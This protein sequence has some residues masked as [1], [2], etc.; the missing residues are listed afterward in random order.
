MKRGRSNS[1]NSFATDSSGFW[2]V[3]YNRRDIET[4]ASL[5]HAPRSARA[6]TVI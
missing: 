5:G 1:T 3:R 2:T 4:R 6:L